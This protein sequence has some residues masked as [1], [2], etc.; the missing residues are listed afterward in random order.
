MRPAARTS[1]AVGVLGASLAAGCSVRFSWPR[2]TLD[3]DLRVS[4]APMDAAPVT[5]DAL[6]M[7]VDSVE[8]VACP[9]A[10]AAPPERSY[11][12]PLGAL[13]ALLVPRAH[14]HGV[15]GPTRLATPVVFDALSL[16]DAAAPLGQ[17]TPPPGAY[18]E[19]VVGF[20]PADDDAVGLEGAPG[21]RDTTLR[22]CGLSAHDGEAFD[23]STSKRAVATVALD[24]PLTFGSERDAHAHLAID[25]PVDAALLGA[26][27]R[28]GTDGAL[29]HARAKLRAHAEPVE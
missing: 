16:G 24:A 25:L 15:P 2:H 8:L 23:W 28:E 6:T 20:G 14:A 3:V 12:D 10:D 19:V 29:L 11:D 13:G 9:D 18:C 26:L 22:A 17:M 5:L 27:A 4:H 21:M 7:V 1:L